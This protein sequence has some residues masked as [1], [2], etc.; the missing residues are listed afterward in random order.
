[1]AFF[2]LL[3]LLLMPIAE[4]GVFIEVGGTLGLWPTL[5]II[6]ATA[7]AGSALLRIQGVAAW[8]RARQSL[9]RNELPLK[10]VFDGFCLLLAGALLL[11]P[12]FITDALGGLLFLPP[13]RAGLRAVLARRIVV[14]QPGVGGGGQPFGSQGFAS[15]RDSIIE[16]DYQVVDPHDPPHDPPDDSPRDRGENQKPA[17]SIPD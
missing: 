9:E 11:T 17:K 2:L 3:A 4:I 8:Q 15:G 7:V 1:M 14:A 13:V 6:A 5:L 16:G 10:E 12:G